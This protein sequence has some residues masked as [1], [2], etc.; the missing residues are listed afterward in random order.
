MRCL[1]PRTVGFKADGKTICWSPKSFSKEYA[2]FQLPC[3]KCIE[4][5]LEYARQWA[6]R[7]VHEASIFEQNSFI[8]LTYADE[9]LKDARLQYRDFQLFIKRLRKYIFTD[10]IK[11][12]GIENW[13]LHTKTEKKHIYEKHTIGI[14]VTGEYGDRTKRPHWHAIIFNW[15]PRDCTKRYT[16]DSGHPVYASA[17]L[18][19]LWGYGKTEVGSVNFDSAGYV[20]RY[21]AKKLVHGDDGHDYEP[22]SKKSS[23]HAIGKRFL[24]KY[25]KDIF[26][27]G[28]VILPNGKKST[29]PRYYE[30]WLLKHHPD[31]WMT[32]VT[33]VKQKNMERSEALEKREQK[34]YWDQTDKRPWN[35]VQLIT[36]TE[37][38][39]AIIQNRF[40]QLLK[41]LKGDI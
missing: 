10:F 15:Q 33:Q 4:C 22:I 20:A 21:A 9:H 17:T 38:R 2:T 18:D 27:H 30:K 11:G 7:C 35:K 24:E 41:Y 34:R 23:K 29:I 3:S 25:W 14:F 40:K 26:V 16:S 19:S 32:Y 5:R 31:A 13:K 8:T 39:K 1:N 6:V 36:K 28:E 12:Y 37:R